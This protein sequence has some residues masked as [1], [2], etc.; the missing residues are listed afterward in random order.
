MWRASPQAPGPAME[1]SG[2]F[3]YLVCLPPSHWPSRRLADN[4]PTPLQPLQL[5]PAAM[6]VC[7]PCYGNISHSHSQSHSDSHSFSHTHAHILTAVAAVIHT[8]SAHPPPHLAS[9]CLLRPFQFASCR[10]KAAPRPPQSHCSTQSYSMVTHMRLS[11]P[12]YFWS[13]NVYIRNRCVLCR[14]G[15]ACFAPSTISN[16]YPPPGTMPTRQ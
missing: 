3:P 6:M 13:G 15:F 9:I 16:K 10:P 14:L 12:T 7:T 4:P 2:H 1:A 11:S 5:A 8:P